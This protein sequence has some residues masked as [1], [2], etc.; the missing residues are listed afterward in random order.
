MSHFEPDP[1]DDRDTMDQ[2]CNNCG[3][4][5]SVTTTTQGVLKR[6][7]NTNKSKPR[8]VQTGRG[9]CGVRDYNLMRYLKH[10]RRL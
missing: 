10:R 3:Y 1:N 7:M 9:R 5:P 4:P 8:L 6:K 2:R